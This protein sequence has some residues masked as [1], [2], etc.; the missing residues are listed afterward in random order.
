MTRVKSV[1]LLTCPLN[2]IT[3]YRLKLEELERIESK[4]RGKSVDKSSPSEELTKALTVMTETSAFIHDSVL[5]SQERAQ[6]L[7]L[8]RNF[9]FERDAFEVSSR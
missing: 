2:H 9:T 5:H 6:M 7:E 3:M 8:Q 4:K 1:T